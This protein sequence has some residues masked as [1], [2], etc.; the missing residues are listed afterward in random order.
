MQIM[1]NWRTVSAEKIPKDVFSLQRIWKPYRLICN[2][3]SL[4]FLHVLN[5]MFIL[6]FMF[7]RVKGKLKN[8]GSWKWQILLT[9]LPEIIKYLVFF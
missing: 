4:N 3:N 8:Q 1:E 7:Q 5:A 6:V 9:S 2:Q